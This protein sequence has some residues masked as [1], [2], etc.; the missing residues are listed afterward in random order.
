MK[1]GEEH[2]C[3]AFFWLKWRLCELFPGFKP[4]FLAR[5]L[6]FCLKIRS[7]MLP[8]SSPDSALDNS[9]NNAAEGTDVDSTRT[10]PVLAGVPMRVSF[11]ESR[12]RPAVCCAGALGVGLALA[13]LLLKPTRATTGDG[14][15][16][17]REIAL[18][19]EDTFLVTPTL[20]PG[21]LLRGKI[22][23]VAGETDALGRAPVGGQVARHLVESGARVERGTAIVEISSGAAQRAVPASEFRQN[24]AERSQIAASDAQNALAQKISIAQ[25]Q[26][27]AAQERIARSQEQVST[28]RDIV[29][30]LQNGQSVAPGEIPSLP[31]AAQGRSNRA[32]KRL[33]RPDRATEIAARQAQAA[34]L[35]AQESTRALETARTM[36]SDAQNAARDA[37][38]KAQSTA[39]SVVEV[40]ARF[41]D[42]K[43]S[44]ADVEA[45]RAAQKE[46]GNA[47]E[48]AAKAV[49]SAKS[50][51]SKREKN[52]SSAQDYA[53]SSAEI[54][55]KALAGARL[56]GS[57]VLDAERESDPIPSA[58]EGAPR[59]TLNSA[60]Q[61]AGAALE[62]SRRASRDAERIHA[63]IEGYQSQV[64][65]SNSRIEAA[66][67]DLAQAQQRVMDSVPRPRFTSAYAPASGIVTWISRLAREVGAG[68]A[69]FGLARTQRVAA[70]FED[71]SGLWRA[72]KPGALL[73]AFVVDAPAPSP[74]KTAA[75][76]PTN[77]PPTSEATGASLGMGHAVE[78]KMTG[79]QA[80]QK[81][82][83]AAKLTGALVSKG[84]G[85]S[86]SGVSDLP[87]GASILVSMPRPGQKPVLSVSA[88]ALIQRGPATYVALLAPL[89]PAEIALQNGDDKEKAR[90]APQ[91]I[92][93]G[94]AS[95]TGAAPIFRLRWARVE[96][97]RSDG[98]RIEI[99]AGLQA[100][101]RVV[102]APEDLEAMG[103]APA[104][105]EQST[106][107]DTKNTTID[108]SKASNPPLIP[109]GPGSASSD[110]V[111]DV[112]VRL[113]TEQ[114]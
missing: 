65:R 30:R 40:E 96:T 5:P 104:L 46:A 102:N 103:L 106:I 32:R 85:V 99:V 68:E 76:L 37:E 52:A 41:D 109:G 4:L 51:L 38:Q 75:N 87:E 111:P 114:A 105:N 84:S 25:T 12:L 58:P 11:R 8:V 7:P 56:D 57:S 34:R 17:I 21:A 74:D 97:G 59:V 64:T 60:I 98:L 62:E 113:A 53:Q 27:R 79:I 112:L 31:R 14:A 77:S 100:G 22:R 43:A 6:H 71:K 19:Q 9:D 90:K 95:A 35:A 110:S 23:L 50:E 39:K 24:R 82:G 20:P 15:Q 42:K 47:A 61:F 48:T 73:S 16:V 107:L 94:A 54:A 28:A 108:N 18:L 88:S 44:G 26:L 13:P 70:R 80:P 89:S 45:A 78:L 93:T 83:E 2:R 33:P 91:K 36:L 72:I 81:Q 63:D 101:A 29:R 92:A 69:V 3:G 66:T 86:A 49:I 55:A 10:S 1:F 67:Q